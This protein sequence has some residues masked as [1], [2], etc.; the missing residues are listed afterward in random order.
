MEYP[1]NSA[2]NLP[3]NEF[4]NN[5]VTNENTDPGATIA[6]INSLETPDPAPSESEEEE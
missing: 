1:S 5:C 2:I 4:V 6:W 3:T